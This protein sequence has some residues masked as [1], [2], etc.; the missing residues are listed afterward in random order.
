MWPSMPKVWIHTGKICFFGVSTA[1]K[2]RVDKKMKNIERSGINLVRFELGSITRQ[3]DGFYIELNITSPNK[4]CYRKTFSFNRL[5][6][7]SCWN[8]RNGNVFQGPLGLL[9][10]IL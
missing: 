7:G 10:S 9:V 2:E 5:L 8:D 4:F 3:A 1:K 6:Y